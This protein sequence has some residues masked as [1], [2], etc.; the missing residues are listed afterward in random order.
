M[1]SPY[2]E[3]KSQ[4]FVRA[5]L[6]AVLMVT[7]LRVGG[8]FAWLWVLAGTFICATALTRMIKIG[9]V[10]SRLLNETRQT[11]NQFSRAT[12]PRQIF[13]LLL[14]VAEVDGR[15]EAEERELVRRFLLE[16]FVDPI[17]HADLRTWEAHRV[18]REQIPV[19]AIQLRQ[20]LSRAECDAVFFWCCLIA[21]ADRSFKDDERVVLH[22]VARGL[23]LPSIESR[24][25]FY[26]AKAHHLGAPESAGYDGNSRGQ[27]QSHGWRA[28]GPAPSRP[29]PNHHA[30]SVLGLGPDATADQIRKRYRQLVKQFHPDAHAHLG[31]VAADEAAKR[32]REI[33]SAYERLNRA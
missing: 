3:E 6:G 18:P 17:T 25:I 32:F 16:R 24:A 30:L 26:Q 23:G 10:E 20:I 2:S 14:G 19:L 31:Q 7:G 13:W 28:R 27:Q 21:F 9:A 29:S 11:F 12:L 4:A 15:A 5:L 8:S 22:E 1:A 33:Q